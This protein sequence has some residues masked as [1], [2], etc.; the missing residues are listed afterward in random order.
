MVV[1]GVGRVLSKTQPQIQKTETE[2]I[3]IS[4]AAKEAI[5][6]KKFITKLGVVPTIVDPIPLYCDNSGAIVQVKETKSHQQSKRI[7]RHYYLFREIVGRNN[8]KI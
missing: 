3:T 4:K 2:Y 8:A 6:I 1:L 7:L 5:W